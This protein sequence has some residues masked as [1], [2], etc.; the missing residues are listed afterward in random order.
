MRGSSTQRSVAQRAA[1][2]DHVLRPAA[3]A[4]RHGACAARRRSRTPGRAVVAQVR[5]AAGHADVERLDAVAE[6][7]APQLR[8]APCRRRCLTWIV[9]TTAS[10]ARKRSPV[11]VS[12][13]AQ[14]PSSMHA[15]AH[16]RSQRTVPPRSSMHADERVGERGPSRRA[17]ASSCAAG[18]RRRSSRRAA[19]SPGRRSAR[20]SGTPA[21][22]GTPDVPVSNSWRMTSQRRQR[23]AAPPDAA[24][25]DARQPLVERAGRSPSGVNVRR[26]E[27][28]A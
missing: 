18:G 16:A 1:E 5:G 19:P 21:R 24:L 8:P 22:A 3:E 7:V 10:R 23:G 9:E 6:V 17:A 15:A 26:A 27:D 4:G 13:P 2:V 11:S 25:A 20:A 14:R 12:T 28:R